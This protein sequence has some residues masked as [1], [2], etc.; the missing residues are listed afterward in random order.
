MSYG[1]VWT[2]Q[3]YVGQLESTKMQLVN[4][5]CYNIAVGRAQIKIALPCLIRTGEDG[6]FYIDHKYLIGKN[7]TRMLYKEYLADWIKKEISLDN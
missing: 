5:N 3:K 4:K 6:W 1:A 2:I 7:E